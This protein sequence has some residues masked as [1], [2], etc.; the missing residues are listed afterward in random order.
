MNEWIRYFLK[1]IFYW[2]YDINTV[3]I[4]IDKPIEKDVDKK[5]YYEIIHKIRNGF[6][7]YETEIEF[8]RH[9]P[10]EQLIEIIKINNILIER[11]NEYIIDH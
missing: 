3:K 8:I 7:L 11:M 9:L 1:F 5:E 2:W 10:K 4:N 6:V